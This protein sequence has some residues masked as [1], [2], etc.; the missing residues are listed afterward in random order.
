LNHLTA[1]MCVLAFRLLFLVDFISIL[2][3]DL[4]FT[5]LALFLIN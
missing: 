5:G 1:F 2:F 3:K 4:L